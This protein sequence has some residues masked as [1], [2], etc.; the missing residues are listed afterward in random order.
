[1]RLFAKFV[2]LVPAVIL[3][4]A[5][6]GG[7]DS[8]K[9]SEADTVAPVDTIDGDIDSPGDDIVAEDNQTTPDVT[10]IDETEPPE[11][12]D[13]ACNFNAGEYCG[14]DLTCQAVAC[15][16]CI[17]NKDCAAGETCFQFEYANG[18]SGSF[19]TTEC[20]GDDDCAADQACDGESSKCV[21]LADCAVDNCGDGGAGDPC[22]YEDVVNGDCG[23]CQDDLT[24]YGIAPSENASCDTDKDCV[25]AGYDS[26][27]NPDC[28]NGLCSASYCVAKCKDFKC[29]EGFE[30]VSAGLGKCV[31]IPLSV[32]TGEAGDACPIWN[33]H[34][35]VESCGPG[36]TCL[37]IPAEEQEGD[38]TDGACETVADCDGYFGFLSPADCVDGYC[39]TSFCSPEC[40]ENDDCENGFFPIDV[41]GNCFCAPTEV[42]DSAAGEAC[43]IFD[44]NPDADACQ[45]GLVC[46]G[47]A[48]DAETD[49]CATAADCDA[50]GYPGGA[51]CVDGH[52]GT[53]FC[54]AKC[55]AEAECDSGYESINVS[56]KCYCQPVQTGDG[57][58]GDACPF[59]VSNED[60]DFCDGALN[61]FGINADETV[62]CDDDSDCANPPYAGNA[63]CV[64]GWCGTSFCS[65][66]CGADDSCDGGFEPLTYEN[67]GIEK[68]NCVPEVPTGDAAAGDPCPL[69]NVN[70]D[71]EYCGEE[72][73]CVGD[74]AME[75]AQ[76]CD[77]AG[78]CDEGTLLGDALCTL[79]YCSSTICMAECA[80]GAT[81]C[82]D[83]AP[84]FYG[85]CFCNLAFEVGTGDAGDAC[86]F[87]TVNAEAEGCKKALVC[88]G[89]AA[90]PDNDDCDAPADC[91]AADYPG[92]IECI[93]GKCASSLC[94]GQCA[95]GECGDGEDV[96]ET[97]S[98]LC[99]CLPSA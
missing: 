60:A 23:Q 84:F 8:D 64:D 74:V 34:F 16:Y 44:V 53:S 17:K 89:I 62:P 43:P 26:E 49:E 87:Y 14:D 65:E 9:G 19:C 58:P 61:C 50:A 90:S 82:A 68:C 77:E 45:G 46:L 28:V 80:A 20:A 5:A 51:V 11:S 2:W 59:G 40:D 7:G 32:G 13:P 66:K 54:S 31:C 42:G 83:G 99:F 98:G 38:P 94:F 55:D 73:A 47:I 57:M 93:D 75:G 63:I 76:T 97:E 85:D 88:G 24:C 78:D 96:L 18:D 92:V 70:T 30:P 56:E 91:D 41:S 33:V 15:T 10:K 35:E 4:L 37:G 72:L 81:L 22:I 29:D 71:A 69:Y 27:L 79:G 67:F 1:M 6:C 12:C 21:P 86:P 48:P 25:L 95:D 52:C 36:L 39:G 3:T